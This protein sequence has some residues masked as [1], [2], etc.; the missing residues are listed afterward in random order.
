MVDIATTGAQELMATALE[1]FAEFHRS[2]TAARPSVHRH[3]CRIAHIFH[4]QVQ[5]LEHQKV[6]GVLLNTH[7]KRVVH[8]IVLLKQL[9]VFGHD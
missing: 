5:V 1:A 4:R 8:E 3:R 7:E 2:L 6:R 9:D